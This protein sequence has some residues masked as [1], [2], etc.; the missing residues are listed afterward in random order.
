MDFPEHDKMKMSKTER[1]I[2][3]RFVDWMAE[4]DVPIVFVTPDDVELGVEDVLDEYFEVDRRVLDNERR[5]KLEVV[6]SEA[7]GAS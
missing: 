2:I 4:R 5:V 3:Q 7:R 1:A 6:R